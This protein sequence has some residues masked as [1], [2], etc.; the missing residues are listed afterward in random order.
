MSSTVESGIS[1]KN[2]KFSTDAIWE[3][4]KK[5]VG[6]TALFGVFAASVYGVLLRTENSSNNHNMAVNSE[7]EKSV[8]IS[9]AQAGFTNIVAVEAVDGNTIVTLTSDLKDDKACRISFNV[10]QQKD[11]IGLV[12]N[13]AEGRAFPSATLRQG[14]DAAQFMQKLC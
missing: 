8:A 14:E 9:L 12:L 7:Q 10:V 5:V 1:S 2:R 11:S 6:K 4:T 3:K 13:D